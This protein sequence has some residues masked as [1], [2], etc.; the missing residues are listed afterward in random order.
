MSKNGD[1]SMLC[2]GLKV[3][4][5]FQATKSPEKAK[6]RLVGHRPGLAIFLIMPQ[7]LLRPGH[8]SESGGE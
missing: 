1:A 7:V 3:M 4:G 5:R 6:P 2:E 8:H